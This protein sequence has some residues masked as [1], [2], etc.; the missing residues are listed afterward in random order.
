MRTCA[1][2]ASCSAHASA[3][4]QTKTKET[5]GIGPAHMQRY[6]VIREKRPREIVLLRTTGCAYRACTFCDYHL[7]RCD[8][9]AA[10]LALN[11]SVLERLTG[12]YGE[13]EIINSGS[14]FDFD[15][16]TLELIRQVCGRCGIST[17]HFESHFMYRDRIPELRRQFEGFELKMKL[18]LETFDAD[19]RERVLHKGIPETD[20]AKIAEGFEEANFLFGLAGQTAASMERDVELGLEHFE[21]VCLNVMCENTTPVH[22]DPAAVEAFVEEVLPRY[23]DDPRVDILVENTGFGVGA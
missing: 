18:G 8:D 17:V 9:A 19:L 4:P 23:A 15:G 5:R 13:V 22:P 1:P 14:V 6:G 12:E 20:P 2:A 10:N 16:P 3:A 11:R 7:D 21:R